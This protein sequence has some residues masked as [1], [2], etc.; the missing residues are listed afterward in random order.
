MR[1]YPQQ[2]PTPQIGWGNTD[3]FFH[4]PN[5]VISFFDIAPPPKSQMFVTLPITYYVR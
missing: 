5:M 3:F 4:F 2:H 1:Y